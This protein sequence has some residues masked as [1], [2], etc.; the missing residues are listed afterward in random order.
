M[1]DESLGRTIRLGAALWALPHG[2]IP[3]EEAPETATARAQVAALLTELGW[4]TL[5][6]GELSPVH[7]SL[8]ASV[9]T[10]FGSGIRVTSAT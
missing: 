2:P 10:P 5:E 7:R 3:D 8:V 1:D 4:T 9:A 6:L